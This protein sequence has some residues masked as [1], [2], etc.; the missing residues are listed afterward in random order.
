M[1]TISGTDGITLKFP[2]DE[3]YKSFK[4]EEEIIQIKYYKRVRDV[5]G[6]WASNQGKFVDSPD[7]LNEWDGRHMEELYH[8]HYKGNLNNG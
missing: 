5:H 4:L 2:D 6:I 3:V 1:R 8:K 7:K